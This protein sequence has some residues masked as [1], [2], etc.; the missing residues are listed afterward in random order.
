MANRV[1]PNEVKDII[2]T[3]ISE[4][5]IEAYITAAN[6]TVTAFL[7]D[8]VL[9][10]PQLKEIERWLTAHLIACSRQRE[11]S[12]EAAG[13]AKVSYVTEYSMFG[14][15]LDATLYGQQ[16]KMLDTTGTLAADLGAAALKSASIYAVTSFDDDEYET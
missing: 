10:A 8:S 11:I 5:S 2:D 9:T 12:D 15:G 6:L 1:D 7:G 16:V 3:S 13:E 14:K 4:A